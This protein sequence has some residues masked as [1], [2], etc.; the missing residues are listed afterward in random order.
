MKEYKFVKIT[1][2]GERDAVKALIMMYFGH[3][4]Y[5]LETKE[6]KTVVEVQVPVS[7]EEIE[8]ELNEGTI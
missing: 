2:T 4:D 3:L 7:T 5:S 8:A 6:D 1:F